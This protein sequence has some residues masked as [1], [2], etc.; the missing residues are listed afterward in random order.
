[1]SWWIPVAVI[2][3]AFLIIDWFIVMGPNPKQWKG[4]KKHDRS[5]RSGR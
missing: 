5:G 3:A 2:A 4:D 1:M